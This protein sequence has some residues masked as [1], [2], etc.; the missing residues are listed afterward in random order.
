[1]VSQIVFGRQR[2]FLNI[3]ERLNG[4]G[5]NTL[6]SEHLSIIQGGFC[7]LERLFEPLQLQNLQPG[8]TDCFNLPFPIHGYA[9]SI[10]SNGSVYNSIEIISRQKDMP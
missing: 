7:P 4:V 5:T 10:S 6:L 9:S 3:L 2:N 8:L 1:M